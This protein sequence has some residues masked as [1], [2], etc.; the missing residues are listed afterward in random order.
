MSAYD[1]LIIFLA[2]P[3]M[4]S[5]ILWMIYEYQKRPRRYFLSWVSKAGYGNVVVTMSSVFD[6]DEMNKIVSDHSGQKDAVA[7][8]VYE[9]E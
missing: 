9:L 6:I 7:M 8:C 1:Y 4:V 5:L 2:I 3:V